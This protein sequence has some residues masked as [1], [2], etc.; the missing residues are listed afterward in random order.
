MNVSNEDAEFLAL[1]KKL[2]GTNINAQ[3][4]LA[5]DYLNHF[6]EIVMTLE[7]VADMPELLDEAKE[8]QPKSYQDHFRD[9]TFSDKGLAVTAYDHAPTRYKKPFETMIETINQ[10]IALSLERGE[11]A[12]ERGEMDHL[13]LIMKDASQAIQKLMDMAGANIHGSESIMDQSEI[14]ILLNK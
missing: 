7:M 12:L 5:T 2:E 10:L 3:T 9:S 14:D 13:S 6:N 8:W 4:F 1:Q 11:S